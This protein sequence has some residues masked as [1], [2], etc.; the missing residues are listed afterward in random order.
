MSSM[1]LWA[2][3]S[4]FIVVISL[5]RTGTTSCL[6]RGLRELSAGSPV[7]KV[8]GA[9]APPLLT[10]HLK[11]HV[12]RKHI[13]PNEFTDLLN[14]LREGVTNPNFAKAKAVADRLS[15][16]NGKTH[17]SSTLPMRDAIELHKAGVDPKTWDFLIKARE[18]DATTLFANE[19][20]FEKIRSLL[21]EECGSGRCKPLSFKRPQEGIESFRFKHEGVTYRVAVC[22]EATR[23]CG[24]A[25]EVKALFPECGP[26]IFSF[27]AREFLESLRKGQVAGQPEMY[28][29][30]VTFYKPRPCGTN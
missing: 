7:E 2:R 20:Q 3:L 6:E 25:G 18:A 30:A 13:L 5:S 4:S 8:F 22:T 28:S 23:T 26:G 24:R 12:L 14:Q 1:Q 17:L 9:E 27:A 16:I 15:E 10:D 19:Q 11:R 29:Q 21:K